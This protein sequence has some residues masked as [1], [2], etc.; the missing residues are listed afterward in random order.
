MCLRASAHE[1]DG[2][3]RKQ[4]GDFPSGCRSLVSL[5]KAGRQSL[6]LVRCMEW[7]PVNPSSDERYFTPARGKKGAREER[8]H[9]S[10]PAVKRQSGHR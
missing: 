4:D 8:K 3:A 10:H 7:L 1:F 2:D 5:T 6:R 9:P